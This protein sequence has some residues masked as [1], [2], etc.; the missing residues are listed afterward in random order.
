M[1]PNLRVRCDINRMG[2]RGMNDSKV[3]VVA[4]GRS[5]HYSAHKNKWNF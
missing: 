2:V 4:L 1:L 5:E 3:C